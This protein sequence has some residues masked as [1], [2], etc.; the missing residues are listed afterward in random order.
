M[1]GPITID[2]NDP[3][4]KPEGAAPVSPPSA[5]AAAPSPAPSGI[6]I[7]PNDPDLKPVA[8]APAPAPAAPT[9]SSETVDMSDPDL[10]P[11]GPTGQAYLEGELSPE[12]IAYLKKHPH[13]QLSAE[14]MPIESEMAA[15]VGTVG[16]EVPLSDK[17]REAKYLKDQ[18]MGQIDARV[19]EL[20]LDP[21]F[22]KLSK[23]ERRQMLSDQITIWEHQGLPAGKFNAAN[24]DAFY[25]VKGKNTLREGL[26]KYA[27]DIEAKGIAGAAEPGAVFDRNKLA[28]AQAPR[29]ETQGLLDPLGIVDKVVGPE[30]EAAAALSFTRAMPGLFG[31]NIGGE[32][33]AAGGEALGGPLGGVIGGVGG[34]LV[35]AF[36]GEK[37]VREAADRFGGEDLRNSMEALDLATDMAT[38][39]HPLAAWGGEALGQLAH[40]QIGFQG[41]LR[42]QTLGE[43]LAPR[44]GGGLIGGGI[45]AASEA[46]RGEDFDPYK[47]G[48]A[49]LSGSVFTKPRYLGHGAEPMSFNGRHWTDTNKIDP[50]LHDHVVQMFK[51]GSSPAQVFDYLRGAL[52]DTPEA[53][54]ALRRVAADIR[55]GRDPEGN[56]NLLPFKP[57]GLDT[58][59]VVDVVNDHFKDATNAPQVH[60][61]DHFNSDTIPEN[62][63]D[64]VG[65]GI[66]GWK[67]DNGEIHIV[68]S[69]HASP[70]AVTGTLFHESMHV[71]LVRAYQDG[72]Q[73]KMVDIF[74][75]ANARFQK[76]LDSKW[77]ELSSTRK[78]WEGMSHDERKALTAEEVLADT[79]E[80][81]PHAQAFDKIKA[82]ISRFGRE[83][84][85]E[86]GKR[87]KY[88]DAEIREILKMGHAHAQHGEGGVGP[89]RYMNIGQ[90]AENADLYSLASY[91]N[92]GGVPE[93]PEYPQGWFQP[94]HDPEHPRYEI[95]D[96][97]A[98][99]KPNLTHKG[100]KLG[101]V[102]EHKQLFEA[103]PH[104]SDVKVTFHE[105]KGSNG[106]WDQ[107]H[108]TIN[109]NP[110]GE[111]PLDTLLHEVQH[112]I[113]DH[114]G[115]SRGASP[116]GI[117]QNAPLEKIYP[118]LEKESD[119]ALGRADR[120]G[121][122]YEA[123][124]AL[125]DD[126]RVKELR[127]MH[128][129][130]MRLD[131]QTKGA[132]FASPERNAAMDAFRDYRKAEDQWVDSV[133]D[134]TKGVHPVDFTYSLLKSDKP[135]SWH[136]ENALKDHERNL[137]RSAE[138]K[139]A[140]GD[141][142]AARK[143]ARYNSDIA[144]HL[145]Y[146][147]GGEYE[148]RATAK[149]RELTDRQRMDEP[150]F[151]KPD[152][153][154]IKPEDLYNP[155]NP[156]RG[157]SK[158]AGY[159]REDI[160]R[161][162]QRIN[163][164]RDREQRKQ[165]EINLR[166]R[167]RARLED[168][169]VRDQTWPEPSDVRFSRK[170]SD[171]FPKD[172]EGRKKRD[173]DTM[174]AHFG[175]FALNNLKGMMRPTEQYQRVSHEEMLAA[176]QEL[177]DQGFDTSL[178]RAQG[179]I[180]DNS[181]FVVALRDLVRTKLETASEVAGRY[182][183]SGG[184]RH[185]RELMR[186]IT[187]LGQIFAVFDTTAS[188]LGRMLH[189]LRLR[190]DDAKGDADI[191][192]IMH[193]VRFANGNLGP[194]E[195]NQIADALMSGN[196]TNI[197][198]QI[199]RFDPDWHKYGKSFFYNYLLGS[200][201]VQLGNILG[202]ATNIV[203]HG[204]G[205]ILG[206]G[207]GKAQQTGE[208]ILAKATKSQP[209]EIDR[210][211]F[212][213]LKARMSGLLAGLMNKETY[214]SHRA[215][216]TAAKEFFVPAGSNAHENKFASQAVDNLPLSLALEYGTRGLQA[217]DAFFRTVL[218][219]SAM[220][221]LATREARRLNVSELSKAKAYRDSLP[222]SP[223]H[224]A[225]AEMIQEAD[226]AVARAQMKI[227]QT[228]H[229]Q[230]ADIMAQPTRKMLMDVKGEAD[231]LLFQ[232]KPFK[233]AEQFSRFMR[234]LP[235]G[236]MLAPIIRTPA[237]IGR[238]AFEAFD[239]TG[240]ATERN[241]EALKR[242]G[243]EANRVRAK[244][245]LAAALWAGTIYLIKNEM[246]NG[247][248]PTNP[249]ARAQ[250]LMS[251]VP[252]TIGNTETG[253]FPLRGISP[254][255]DG[256]STIADANETM[257]FAG[258]DSGSSNAD[259][260]LMV[261]AGM[262]D[263]F[264]SN[265][266]MSP[267]TDGLERGVKPTIQNLI[268][269]LVQSAANVPL[270]SQNKKGNDP[271]VRD[272]SSEG[273]L[274]PSLADKASL[275]DNSIMEHYFQDVKPRYNLP[276]RR[277]PFGAPIMANHPTSNDPIATEVGRLVE[278]TGRSVVPS[279]D[280]SI[281]GKHVPDDL[282]NNFMA[283]AG[284]IVR[285]ATRQVMDDPA[286]KRALTDEQRVAIFKGSKSEA[287]KRLNE[288]HKRL[289]NQLRLMMSN[290]AADFYDSYYSKDTKA[291]MAIPKKLPEIK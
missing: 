86:I 216:N 284:P 287:S 1:A 81:N 132:G 230:V 107:R 94:I 218:E 264:L 260:A 241:R 76:A 100:M 235:G 269:T 50:E 224:N 148:A 126:P 78:D 35:G 54:G 20:Y 128:E 127:A 174:R 147:A 245:M 66:L 41:M 11:A 48:E 65:P 74:D 282:F 253:F 72:L 60:V 139:N 272:T 138:Y 9:A 268:G 179:A 24:P 255:G 105:E 137:Q 203:H 6:T 68:A 185:E 229:Q 102:L 154:D 114:E 45:E 7:D 44:L 190:L 144:D 30:A 151:Q 82:W 96:E 215:F 37:L 129:H 55:H 219:H 192:Q 88:S 173:E 121:K 56:L 266:F 149:R 277:D 236:W 4:L 58:N 104:L 289:N 13:R 140:I 166:E 168:E 119:V 223:T 29:L 161:Y 209:R 152:A 116:E 85:G 113:Q 12:G 202:N 200:S 120:Y 280:R 134:K 31:G 124:N 242:G 212:D 19:R 157:L 194:E 26:M 28:V 69:Q 103:Y 204:L 178:A 226:D 3:D 262:S 171:Q 221:G 256:L 189:A 213:E 233:R 156:N 254:I 34:S 170:Y 273:S 270:Y 182:K 16:E 67:D 84:L 251:H 101:D 80:N 98:R 198:K 239:V 87:F 217:A 133:K 136:I 112:S 211:H 267:V 109:I 281:N 75:N 193:N 187:D 180:P 177:K 5:V 232:E 22:L 206:Y 59:K 62:M 36:G 91:E 201:S 257:K 25:G 135:I 181:G 89:T 83:N 90:K 162:A 8:A 258:R 46:G 169:K 122:I 42:G 51:A 237:N 247:G 191:Q 117:F 47:M 145:Y 259:K 57:N 70:A 108:N 214:N 118:A 18:S 106:S 163:E 2:P 92:D 99:W 110:K 228:D 261:A 276:I 196:T 79:A 244:Q 275:Q 14:A 71:G 243:I 49:A 21:D 164:D 186:A 123:L 207:I 176:G 153:K 291:L 40:N 52:P 141:E 33:G 234:D 288:L 238:T 286:Y 184:M 167:N 143:L 150:Q 227:G 271:F 32:L 15:K 38:E 64:K 278:S 115:F 249:A 265:S 285:E 39:A 283:Y 165:V 142:W 23:D 160:E 10:K 225:S 146:S 195:L 290:R 111:H 61:H 222:D 155:A 63:R 274:L 210:M 231:R 205:D 197:R 130:M 125:K 252:Y 220:Q 43:A 188:N 73:D 263:A 183:Q 93:K 53:R 250:W 77:A 175:N 279:F 158:D 131:D 240:R 208:N 95:S 159:T 17:E 248:G 246:L 27:D 97:D 199:D 172:Y